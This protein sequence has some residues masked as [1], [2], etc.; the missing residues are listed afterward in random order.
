[1]FPDYFNK[2]HRII[3]ENKSHFNQRIKFFDPKLLFVTMTKLISGTNKEGYDITLSQ[4]FSDINNTEIPTKSAFCQYRNTV[5]FEF[6]KDQYSS[7]I[8]NYNI[9]RPLYK[10]LKINAVDGDQYWLPRTD[11]IINNGYSG[12]TCGN[13]RI[14]YYL[15]MYAITVV[16]CITGVPI[17]FEYSNKLNENLL[18]N[19]KY[20]PNTTNDSISIYDRLYLSKYLISAHKL[21]KSYFVAR[22]KTKSTFKEIVDFYDEAGS[23]NKDIILCDTNLRLIKKTI[24]NSVHVFVT[25]IPQDILSDEEIINIYTH[26]WEIEIH[27]KSMT[28]TQKLE[29]FHST[30]LNGILQEIYTSLWINAFTKIIIAAKINL[31]ETF[32]TKIYFKSNFKLLYTYLCT[33]LID[34]FSKPTK[35]ISLFI[36]ELVLKYK[37]K[38]KRFKSI[39]ERVTKQP[40]KNRYKRVSTI[41]KNTS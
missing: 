16:D 13:N 34:I 7:L 14:T 26:R 33:K 8:K 20:I 5:S 36:E 19:T 15:K 24:G 32:M 2:N 22:G 12:Q 1:M 4:V 38:R 21:A 29:Q 11:D 10:G 17:Q 3:P 6:F 37:V 30:Y 31:E 27:N 28:D 35:A 39:T 40:A 23:K 41:P 18:A 25:N 9:N